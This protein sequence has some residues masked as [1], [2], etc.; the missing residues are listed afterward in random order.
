MSIDRFQDNDRKQNRI[1]FFTFYTRQVVRFNTVTRGNAAT[2]NRK[3]LLSSVAKPSLFYRGTRGRETIEN[4]LL[5][6][7][8]ADAAV[9][10]FS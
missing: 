2:R 8:R 7:G 10:I 1:E 9:E 3:D 6:E 4:N 5:V